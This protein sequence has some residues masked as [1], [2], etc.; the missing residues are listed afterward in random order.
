MPLYQFLR[1]AAFDQADIDRMVA[2]YEAAL[3]LL[4]M[5]DR[6]DPVCELVAKKIIEIDRNGEHDPPRMCARALK[7]LGIPLRE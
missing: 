3:K 6:N 4:G 1:E 7:E 5:T 2:A